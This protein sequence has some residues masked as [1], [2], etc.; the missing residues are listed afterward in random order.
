MRLPPTLWIKRGLIVLGMLGPFGAL[1]W[2]LW[3]KPV[4][5]DVAEIRKVPSSSP[6]TRRARPA[7]RTYT[8]CRHPSP[9]SW[10]GS[11]SRRAIASGRT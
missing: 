5:V 4:L 3:P 11:R 10:C 7:S 1:A 6:S 9:A 8:R 2:T